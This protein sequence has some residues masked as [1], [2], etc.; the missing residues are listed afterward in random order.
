MNKDS[1]ILIT[2]GAGFIG[3]NLCEHLYSK[4]GCNIWSLDNYSTGSA[5]NH[6][7]NVTYINGETSK[8]DE[9]ID[10]SP[11]Y[12]FHFGEYSRVEQSFKD[13]EKVWE[14]N[15]QSIF[16]ILQFCLKNETKLIYSG[17]S[18]K[19][20]DGGSGKD[21]SPYAFSK[22][23]NSDFVR[24]FGSWFNLNYAIVYFYNAYGKREISKGEYATLIGIYKENIIK[25]KPLN[26]VLPG[27]QKRNFTHIDDIT[28]ALEIVAKKSSQDVIEENIAT[29]KQPLNLS[30]LFMH[31]VGRKI[32]QYKS[33]MG[34]SSSKK[35]LTNVA[36]F[37]SMKS[38]TSARDPG[39]SISRQASTNRK[40]DQYQVQ[41]RIDIVFIIFQNL[42][43][44]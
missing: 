10:F 12:L 26:V 34:K 39:P 41:G 38:A 8:I 40:R 3:S 1:K 36:S 21:Q 5:R 31:Q 19:F 20:G 30:S 25:N 9:L 15:T 13:I 22:A 42:R 18:T 4:V 6:I 2:G 29:T 32:N 33:L 11:D 7:D 28:S 44:K 23:T 43:E 14:Y 16:K 24:N 37:V 17:S 27:T 35:S